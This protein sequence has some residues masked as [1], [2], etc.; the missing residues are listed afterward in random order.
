MDRFPFQTDAFREQKTSAISAG[1]AV[2]HYNQLHT[3][4]SRLLKKHKKIAVEKVSFSTAV[5][6]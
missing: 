4:N 6:I 1:V 5:S 3:P 2:F